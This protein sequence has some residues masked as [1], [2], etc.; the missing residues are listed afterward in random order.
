MNRSSLGDN[1]HGDEILLPV[2]GVY[3]VVTMACALLLNL[4]P[5]PRWLASAAPDFVA[6]VILYW[7]VFQPHRVG[8]W[9]AWALGL[10]MD[11]ANASLFGQH[12]LAYCG[13]AY[14][15]IFLH[16]RIRMFPM[17]YQIAHVLA[18][19]L[20]QQAIQLLIRLVSSAEPPDMLYFVSSLTG[21]ALWPAIVAILMLPMRARPKAEEV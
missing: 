14:A 17:S 7:S 21:A 8:L 20:G 13:I 12:A 2:R 18:I 3:I 1:I 4:I 10:L 19:L 5:V 16:R 15:G 11:V 6:L 9:P